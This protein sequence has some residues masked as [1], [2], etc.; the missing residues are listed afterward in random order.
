[1]MT[2]SMISEMYQRFGI[3]G[4]EMLKISCNL[5]ET[6]GLGLVGYF[7]FPLAITFER[8]YGTARHDTYEYKKPWWG[9]FSLGKSIWKTQVWVSCCCF[10]NIC[11]HLTPPPAET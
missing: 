8:A 2:Y 5:I 6:S 7:G 4:W 10:L 1:M 9:I 11:A 3:E